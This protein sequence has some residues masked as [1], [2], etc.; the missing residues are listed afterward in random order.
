MTCSSLAGWGWRLYGSEG[1]FNC[2]KYSLSLWS[3]M[4]SQYILVPHH[5]FQQ[6]IHWPWAQSLLDACQ[7][8]DEG[9]G[10]TWKNKIGEDTEGNVVLL[11]LWT[12]LSSSFASSSHLIFEP[13]ISSLNGRTKDELLCCPCYWKRINVCIYFSQQWEGCRWKTWCGT[14]NLCQT[15]LYSSFSETWGSNLQNYWVFTA[16]IV[17]KSVYTV[18]YNT[19]YIKNSPKPQIGCLSGKPKLRDNPDC[20]QCYET[21]CFLF[22]KASRYYCVEEHVKINEGIGNTVCSS[23]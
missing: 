18:N 12:L 14:T 23:Q 5:L 20:S 10:R 13:Y 16:S 11:L 6:L 21:K 17:T 1:W 3:F 19:N 8:K 9:Q 2:Q 22:C 4:S 15:N 7:Q